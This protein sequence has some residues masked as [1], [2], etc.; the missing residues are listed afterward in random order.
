MPR[1]GGVYSPPAGTKGVP[2]ATIQSVPYNTLID[3]LAADANAPRP[4][5]AGGTG[6]T[7]A[8]GAR[9]AL[10]VEVGTNV[11]AYDAGLQSIS[12]LVTSADQMIYTTAADVYATTALTPFARTLLNNTNADA[13]KT[14]LGLTAVASTASA[15]DLTTGTLADARMPTAMMGK[16]F[17]SQVSMP[18]LSLAGTFGINSIE[19]G[20]GDNATWATQN[21]KFKGWYGMGMCDHADNV[22]GVYNFRTGTWE[23]KGGFVIN[24]RDVWSP[25]NFD[26]STKANL[27]G[28][29]FSGS[30]TVPEIA[31]DNSSNRKIQFRTSVGTIRGMVRHDQTNDAMIISMF[32]SSGSWYRD[33]VLG[34]LNGYLSWGG[35][36]FRI[37]GARYHDNGNVYMPWAGMY[38]SEILDSKITADGRS[39]P[40]RVGGAPINFHWSGQGGQPSWLWGGND[41]QEMYVYNP[42]NFNVNYAN[43]AGS[44][45]TLSNWS[46]WAGTWIGASRIGG[47]VYQNTTGRWL[48]I[49]ASGGNNGIAIL[50][51]P[52]AATA[53]S[54]HYAGYS[55][56]NDFST[57]GLVP[58]G[59]YY[60]FRATLNVFEAR[61]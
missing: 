2:N 32:N 53:T 38:L 11:Q 37:G 5:T 3:D 46:G 29:G 34:G 26:P 28:A 30:I 8:S 39:Y 14:R 42:S 4:V 50:Y 57:F 12:G 20:N 7:S 44:A 19:V 55:G 47:T 17:T 6:A 36:E 27:S 23:V 56:G 60:S 13:I 45:A 58:P 31:I 43:S 48:P 9:A 10:G 22:N 61:N 18:S 52:T 59:W 49:S 35:S 21:I 54:A 33:L 24:G 15:S 40:R 1:T 25:W 16:A 51:G 41:G